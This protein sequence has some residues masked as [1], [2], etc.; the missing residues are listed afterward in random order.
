[1]VFG[2]FWG[3]TYCA[4]QQENALV[5]QEALIWTGHYAGPLDG[6]LGAG[7]LAAIKRFQ[8]GLS[9]PGT[10]ILTEPQWAA[11]TGQATR[12][13]T[14]VGFTE[15]LDPNTGVSIGMP[16][17]LVH[18]KIDSPSE[19][20]YVASSGDIFVALRRY[21]IEN[22]PTSDFNSLV[23][24]LGA[25]KI[26]YKIQKE[27]WFV[28]A[29]TNGGKKYYIR[30]HWQ[31][32][33]FSGFYALYNG[34]Q[35]AR[36]NPALVMMS[37]KM[38]A[39]ATAPRVAA[40]A[41]LRSLALEAGFSD[42]LSRSNQS[43]AAPTTA[44]LDSDPEKIPRNDASS[45]ESTSRNTGSFPT[46]PTNA[47]NLLIDSVETL[48]KNSQQSDVRFYRYSVDKSLLAGFRSDMPV[49]RVVFEEQVF[50]D[51]DKSAI[52]SE[53]NTVLT[54]I[55][56]TLRN[57][58]GPA[59]LFVTGHAD[60]RGS[61][62]Y[63]LNLS[64]RRADAV[65]RALSRMGVGSAAIWRVGF[66]KAVPLRPNSNP[67][68]M[69]LNRRVEFLVATQPSIIAAW[70]NSSKTLC[71]RASADCGGPTDPT[72]FVALPI[73]GFGAKPIPVEIPARPRL[74][75]Q[76]EGQAIRPPIPSIIPQRPS[77]IE[78]MPGTSAE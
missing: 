45:V 59:A 69:A 39:F 27:N 77:L 46:E 5:I 49:L 32:G 30:F 41:P 23:A 68:N 20:D 60:S 40:S 33:A 34:Q 72:H 6:S 48:L 55:A 10:G 22:D 11:L 44:M 52:R 35:A 3:A 51:T 7:S 76:E 70:I 29:G 61:D 38:N 31:D 25:S 19:S 63:N 43:P 37:S 24:L 18:R 15:I 58:A 75:G 67:Q 56:V 54:S 42:L 13:R 26:E 73:A 53:A 62:E 8:I 1:L 17:S 2:P 78:L 74:N 50:F 65:A 14:Q 9:Q 57:Q 47:S 66:G 36:F 28:V 4:A 16:A 21:Q 71:E 12:A 64:A